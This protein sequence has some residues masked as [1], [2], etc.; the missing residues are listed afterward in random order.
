MGE[1]CKHVCTVKKGHLAFLVHCVFY[2]THVSTHTYLHLPYILTPT[3][4]T[5]PVLKRHETPKKKK[6]AQ[7]L[8]VWF[9]RSYKLGMAFLFLL[10]WMK[11]FIRVEK[12]VKRRFPCLQLWLYWNPATLDLRSL[13][14][15]L[16]CSSVLN[17]WWIADG[18]QAKSLHSPFA[19]TALQPLIRSNSSTGRKWAFWRNW[20]GLVCKDKAEL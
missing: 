7:I 18:S 12:Y 9:C 4:P 3:T 20:C 1:L 16:C 19:A 8:P 14:I 13:C 6:K 5:A 11:C 2:G 10:Q 17:S 15:A